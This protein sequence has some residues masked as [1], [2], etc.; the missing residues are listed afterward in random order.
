MKVRTDFFPITDAQA[1]TSITVQFDNKDLQ[2]KSTEGYQKAIVHILG[3]I[4]TLTHRPVNNFEEEVTVDSPNELLQQYA[5]RK[6]IYQKTIPLAPGTY[7]LRVIVKDQVAGNLNHMEL[8]LVVPRM[9]S[10]KLSSSSLVLA[11]VLEPVPMK[12]IGKDMFVVGDTKVRPRMDS[13]FKRDEKM[14]IYLKLYNFEPDETTKKPTGQVSF[15]VVRT[16]SNERVFPEFS[17][18]VMDIPNASSH[19]VTVEKFLNLKDFAPGQYTLRIKV[20]DK[21]RNQVLTQQAQFTVT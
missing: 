21:N 11:D 14:G 18:D 6:S 4:T 2:F 19:Q 10:E 13:S 16:S 1:L 8:P 17:E 12:S 5:S 20:T 7:R 9:D 3:T 15:E